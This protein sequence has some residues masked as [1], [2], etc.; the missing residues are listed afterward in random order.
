MVLQPRG[1]QRRALGLGENPGQRWKRQARLACGQAAKHDLLRLPQIGKAIVRAA[2]HGPL[3]QASHPVALEVNGEW[4]V[5]SGRSHLLLTTRHLPL[6]T[7][8]LQQPT[9]LDRQQK[10]QPVHQP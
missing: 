2:L 6:P 9:L 10:D 3:A 5:A 8:L 4:R 7:R 1:I